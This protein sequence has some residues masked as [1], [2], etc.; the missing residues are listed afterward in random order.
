MSRGSLIDRTEAVRIVLRHM[1]GDVHPAEFPNQ[2][3]RVIIL[4]ATQSYAF[5]A[6][7]GFHHEHRCLSFCSS[8]G[9]GQKRLHQKSV[10]VLHQYMSHV[11]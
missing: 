9:L 4:V 10:A 5:A 6:G 11:I 3:S 8:G 1:R 7:D 2:F